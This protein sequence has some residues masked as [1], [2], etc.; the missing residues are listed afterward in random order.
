M[1]SIQL[2]DADAARRLYDAGHSLY[3]RA[4]AELEAAVVP[5]LL[6]A[7]GHGVRLAPTDRYRRGE[8]ETF[9]S[10][11][12]HVTSW[13]TDFQENFTVQLSGR[14]RWTFSHSDVPAPLRGCTPHFN[15]CCYCCCCCYSCY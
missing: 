14:K 2:D 8:V 7:L 11:A 1:N 15:R 9:F 6:D 3:C 10:R 4:P 12:G 13:H 5:R